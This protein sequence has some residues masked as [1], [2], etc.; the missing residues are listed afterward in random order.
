[1]TKKPTRTTSGGKPVVVDYP[2]ENNSSGI[3]RANK[4]KEQKRM[5]TREKKESVDYYDVL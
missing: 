5:I 3:I 2:A 1:V 4:R